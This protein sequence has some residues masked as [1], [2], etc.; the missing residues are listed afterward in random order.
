MKTEAE[1]REELREA[2]R[3][4]KFQGGGDSMMGGT[5]S[6]MEHEYEFAKRPRDIAESL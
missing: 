2:M 6:E 3:N 5:P 4:L 1:R